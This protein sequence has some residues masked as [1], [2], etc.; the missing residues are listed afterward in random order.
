ML[1][2]DLRA[3]TIKALMSSRSSYFDWNACWKRQSN[4]HPTLAQALFTPGDLVAWILEVAP[5]RLCLSELA[6]EAR[7]CASMRG[8][9]TAM[10]YFALHTAMSTA[11][12]SATLTYPSSVPSADG[13]PYPWIWLANT[14]QVQ[15]KHASALK[16]DAGHVLAQA[17]KRL[18]CS[19]SDSDGR[20]AP[21]LR[22]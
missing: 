12:S 15:R 22:A 10:S 21:A 2:G 6:I 1:S 5:C 18:S 8:C 4:V 11:S 19:V 14:T 3:D 17:R 20:D 9:Q 16:V 13:L 7:P